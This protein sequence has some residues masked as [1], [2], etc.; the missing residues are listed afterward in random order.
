MSSVPNA[1]H[2]MQGMGAWLGEFKRGFYNNLDIVT[3]ACLTHN[4]AIPTAEYMVGM[5]VFGGVHLI[6]SQILITNAGY[7]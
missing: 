2:V 3:S 4:K 7:V 5:Q 1:I 6:W